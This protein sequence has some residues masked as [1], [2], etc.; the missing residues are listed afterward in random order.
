MRNDHVISKVVQAKLEG[1]RD[2]E[3][4]W[5]ITTEFTGSHKILDLLEEQKKRLQ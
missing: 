3:K 4:L 2:N 1:K 5:K